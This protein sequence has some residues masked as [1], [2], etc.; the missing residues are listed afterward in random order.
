MAGHGRK[1]LVHGTDH[2]MPVQRPVEHAPRRLW[3]ALPDTDHL[4]VG[5]ELGRRKCH[6]AF[7]AVNVNQGQMRRGWRV[8]RPQKIACSPVPRQ[9]ENSVERVPL[10]IA[11]PYNLDEYR[12]WHA[13]C[14]CASGLRIWP[15]R[16]RARHVVQRPARAAGEKM[17]RNI[18]KNSPIAL[19]QLFDIALTLPGRTAGIMPILFQPLGRVVFSLIQSP[20]LGQTHYK[21]GGAP[22]WRTYARFCRIFIPAVLPAVL[23]LFRLTFSIH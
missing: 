14:P 1:Q 10:D 4:H 6:C 15:A 9:A 3:R 19:R 2:G 16:D 22:K 7:V 13:G 8:W 23:Q 20:K 11:E 21:R 18:S 5:T 12:R 17:H